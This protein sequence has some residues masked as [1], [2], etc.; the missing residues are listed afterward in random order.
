MF[1]RV[2]VSGARGYVDRFTAELMLDH[3]PAV[4]DRGDLSIV[5]AESGE[6]FVIPSDCIVRPEPEECTP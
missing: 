1:P 2:T 6:I 5:R 4:D 3:Y